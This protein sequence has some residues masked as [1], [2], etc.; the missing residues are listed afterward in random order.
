MYFVQ[1]EVNCWGQG[2]YVSGYWGRYAAGDRVGYIT[3]TRED[4]SLKTKWRHCWE[5]KNDLLLKI[6]QG[7][8]PVEISCR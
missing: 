3:G 8:Q 7:V 5:E 6:I 4:R 1:E 2:G